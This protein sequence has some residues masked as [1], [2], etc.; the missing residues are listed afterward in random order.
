MK[1]HFYTLLITLFLANSGFAQMEIP[2]PDLFFRGPDR[3]LIESIGG[4]LGQTGSHIGS[5]TNGSD[6]INNAGAIGQAFAT[7]P[8]E[9]LLKATAGQ[10]QRVNIFFDIPVIEGW[11]YYING[12]NEDNAV[13]N[14]GIGKNEQG[15]AYDEYIT[16]NKGTGLD[17]AN[18]RRLV[19][20]TGEFIFP[21]GRTQAW[22]VFGFKINR[23][24]DLGNGAQI[25]L[26][27][28][29]TIVLPYVVEG[30]SINLAA[31]NAVTRL[32]TFREPAVPHMILHNPPGDLSSTT[33]ET[34]T[35]TCR[36]ISQSLANDE[37]TSANLKLTLG[38]AGSAGLFVTTNFEFSASISGGVGA[39]ASTVSSN[40][41]Q[42]CLTVQRSIS[43]Q[44]GSPANEGSIYMGYSSE[45]A[46]G[47]YPVVKIKPGPNISVVKDSALIFASV[48]NSAVDFYYT[49]ADILRDMQEK[50]SI[51]DA[52]TDNG[53]KFQAL[54]Q[55]DV[56]RQVLR[57]DSL[58]INNPS[59]EVI[60]GGLTGN[61]II[62]TGGQGPNPLST[63]RT[64]S[65]SETIEVSNFI[66]G[67]FGASF[68]AKFGGSGVEGGF[69][70]KTRRTMGQSVNVNSSSDVTVS[71]NLQDDD[72]GDQFTVKVVKDP[73]YGTPIF[74]LDSLGSRTSC[75]YEGG[76]QRDK[77][78]LEIN[79]SSLPNITVSNVSL[80]NAGNFKVKICNNSAE[81]R[82]YGF[83]F[84]NESVMSD[85]F[86]SSTAGTGSSPF[87]ENITKLG[88]ITAIP[89]RGCKTTI[90]DVNVARRF[91]NSPM[92]Y[93]NIE[94]VTFAECEPEI[95]SSIFATVNFAT[96]PP[97]T[98][99]SASTKEICAGTPIQLTGNCPVGVPTWY[100]D[101][102]GGL[103]L[104]TGPTLTVNPSST[105]TYYLGCVAN[106]YNRDRVGTGEIFVTTPFPTLNLTSDLSFNALQIANTTL[107][108]TNKIIDPAR[109]TYKAGNS[110]TFSPGFE[111][112]SGST[113]E[114][115]IGGCGN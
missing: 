100:D 83:G 106:L 50:Q 96:P 66:E 55:V 73:T 11:K 65:N 85:V 2:L 48:P 69:E 97:P 94:F 93:P 14:G 21:V 12:E 105:T 63:S 67:S 114:A 34:T 78:K 36:E 112:K 107:T 32:G 61:G 51:A 26:S 91:A 3:V 62:F 102:T 80:G 29:H 49:K 57:N 33:F 45:I 22:L 87:G 88:L 64:I 20:Y 109:V 40:G 79:G 23:V 110:L 95:R 10:T 76:I 46:Y 44:P 18:G 56:W 1:R 9:K 92:S 81:V 13:I 86:I 39:G 113:F 108:A 59:N 35:N 60:A 28:Y 52:A 89:A 101:P 15:Y 77:P 42:S 71:Y 74:L 4:N 104:G 41:S 82:D 103:E 70:F 30:V 99:V 75:P 6:I 47:L 54:A 8:T 58:N 98:N 111:A 19:A 72:G 84:V 31:P 43:T 17:L 38:I 115:K 53:V 25:D 90:Y 27:T 7:T 68:V 24:F 5:A 16:V 37:S